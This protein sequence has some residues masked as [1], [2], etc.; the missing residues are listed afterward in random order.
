M[1]EHQ[2]QGLQV[3]GFGG[4]HGL[5]QV[6]EIGRVET[7]VEDVL[8]VEGAEVDLHIIERIVDQ[9]PGRCLGRFAH[10]VLLGFG[11]GPLRVFLLL[12]WR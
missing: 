3:D 10:A 11:F 1:Q 12:F 4:F 6:V 5:E 7:V 2:A 8:E 9:C